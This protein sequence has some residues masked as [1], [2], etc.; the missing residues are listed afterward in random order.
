MGNRPPKLLEEYGIILN[1]YRRR[2]EKR[3]RTVA[4]AIGTKYFTLLELL[5]LE[6]VNIE[7]GEK[8]YI[9]RGF[10][11]K[12]EAVL[13]VLRYEELSSL[14]RMELENAVIKIVDE[15]E[16][17]FLSF[18]NKSKP[19]NIRIHE[20][21]LLPGIGRKT[22][23]K[24]LDERSKKPFS[25]FDDLE[26]RTDVRNPKGAIIQR[27]LEELQTKCRHSLFV[28]KPLERQYP[29]FIYNS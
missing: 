20:L 18:F 25:S 1:I 9:G 24:I 5:I 11:L 6:G 12:V 19:I 4:E 10:R 21:N 27:I 8:V 17:R 29:R 14:A 2:V 3:V 26:E 16:E 13:R 28:A 22:M 15:N 7:V 23:W